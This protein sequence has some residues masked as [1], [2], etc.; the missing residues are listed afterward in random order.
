MEGRWR[1]GVND[2]GNKVVTWWNDGGGMLVGQWRLCVSMVATPW[3]ITTI[4][5]HSRRHL[6]PIKG[7]G[8]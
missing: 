7:S 4:P 1:R 3:H 2:G 5:P 8:T 6:L